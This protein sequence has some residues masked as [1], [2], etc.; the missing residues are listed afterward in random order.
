MDIYKEIEEEFS[1]DAFTVRYIPD[2]DG[3]F[4]IVSVSEFKDYDNEV[5]GCLIVRFQNEC[6]TVDT[7]QVGKTDFR[8]SGSEIV[9]LSCL[10]TFCEERGYDIEIEN[11]NNSNEF[12]GI[13]LSLGF[14]KTCDGYFLDR[15]DEETDEYLG[16]E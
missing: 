1:K 11:Q 3:E 16:L 7:I 13:A 2:S 5:I 12:D 6:L 4:E 9:I 8:H 10:C 15:C 14:S